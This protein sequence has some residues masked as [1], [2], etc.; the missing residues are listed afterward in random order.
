MCLSCFF[1]CNGHLRE[2]IFLALRSNRLLLSLI[3]LES[4]ASFDYADCEGKAL[5]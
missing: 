3:Q 5:F 4:T 1:Q 2:K